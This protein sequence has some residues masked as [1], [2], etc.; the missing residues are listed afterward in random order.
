MT[1]LQSCSYSAVGVA[2]LVRQDI[3]Q[4]NLCVSNNFVS[5]IL[6][7]IVSGFQ[8]MAQYTYMLGKK[9][10]KYFR[11]AS[12]PLF[13]FV[14]FFRQHDAPPEKFRR[15]DGFQ[16]LSPLYGVVSPP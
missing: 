16:F 3:R 7:D 13:T 11:K 10:G 6:F 4:G 14:K 5:T 9:G 2:G 1:D 12:M 8:K 15:Y